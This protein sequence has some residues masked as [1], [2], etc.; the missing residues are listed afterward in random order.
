MCTKASTPIALDGGYWVLKKLL[1]FR[2]LYSN[3][4]NM[5]FD[6]GKTVEYVCLKYNQVLS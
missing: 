4:I 6:L 3:Y 5:G 1:N 2:L